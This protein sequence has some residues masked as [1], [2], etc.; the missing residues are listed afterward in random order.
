MIK[1]QGHVGDIFIIVIR[2]ASIPLKFIKKKPSLTWSNSCQSLR[3]RE[4]RR[5]CEVKT[6]VANRFNI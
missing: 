1:G 5:A 2:I 6:F 4:G 3:Y